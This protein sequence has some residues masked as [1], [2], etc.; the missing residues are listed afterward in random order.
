MTFDE[1]I[2]ALEK[3]NDA[4]TGATVIANQVAKRIKELE[5]KNKELEAKNEALCNAC[6]YALD[7]ACND[8]RN[9]DLIDALDQ[10]ITKAKAE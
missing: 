3:A 4:M 6:F 9:Q 8:N 1:A 2:A 10:A 7:E 5:A